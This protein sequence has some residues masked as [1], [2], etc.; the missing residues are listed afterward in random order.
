MG[1]E[2]EGKVEE[3]EEEGEKERKHSG[4]SLRLENVRVWRGVERVGMTSLGYCELGEKRVIFLGPLTASSTTRG[5][6]GFR[7]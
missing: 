3:R 5:C 1:H 2:S 7:G 4:E 6:G